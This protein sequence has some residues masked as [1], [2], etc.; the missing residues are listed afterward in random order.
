MAKI[1]TE[2]YENLINNTTPAWDRIRNEPETQTI[3][4]AAI[5]V[6]LAELVDAA[7][8]ANEEG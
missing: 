5:V 8:K 1:G 4:L 3:C 7:H 2:F 6:L